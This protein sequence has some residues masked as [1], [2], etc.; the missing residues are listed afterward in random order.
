MTDCKD[1]IGVTLRAILRLSLLYLHIHT[2]VFHQA[3]TAFSYARTA[4]V[5]V[6]CSRCPLTSLQSDVSPVTSHYWRAHYICVTSVQTVLKTR[7]ICC[8]C[9][10]FDVHSRTYSIRTNV[11]FCF[12]VIMSHYEMT[13]T[14]HLMCS[15]NQF[16]FAWR[17]WMRKDWLAPAVTNE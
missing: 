15:T 13:S 1:V 4:F 12:L 11:K 2:A 17:S 6:V 10:Q 7:S 14:C 16:D 5:Y 3:A 8:F 9:L